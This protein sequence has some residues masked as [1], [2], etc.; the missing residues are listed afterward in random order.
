MYRLLLLAV[1]LPLTAPSDLGRAASKEFDFDIVAIAL[2]GRQTNLTH[3]PAIDA[4]PAVARDGRIVFVSNREGNP[5][6][7]LMDGDG[8]NVT[9]LTNGGGVALDE[10][11]EWTQASWS[12]RGDSVAFDGKY[13]ALGPPCEQHCAGWNVLV[14]RSDGSGLRRIALGA[15]APDWSRDGRRLVYASGLDAYYAAGSVTISRLD[16][17][18]TVQVKAI[19]GFS[20]VGPVWS[21]GGDQ[22]AFQA[23]PAEGSGT[24]IY[25]I[26]ADGRRRRRLA[27]GHHPAWSPDGKRLA[28]IDHC[29]LL[30]IGRNG[31]GRRRLSRN[32][33][34]VIGA[35]WS[36]SGGMLAYVAGTQASC[37][38][39]PRN[40][41]LETVTTDGKRV[42][43]LARESRS[44]RFVGSGP[45]WTPN[46]RRI[47]LVEYR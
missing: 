12:P 3:N 41:R 21:P 11:L 25:L 7:Y 15:R 40:L 33:E 4:A 29:R 20:S 27:P 10:D 47:L 44:S 38:G 26:G 18:A 31:N 42:H 35:A 46:G 5:D 45:V 37:A 24:S 39:G 16:G 23:Q 34:L 17:S 6:L 1:V 30:T 36:P 32:G 22:V 8:R 13:E 9:K 2:S 43:V 28:Y 19:N 14:V